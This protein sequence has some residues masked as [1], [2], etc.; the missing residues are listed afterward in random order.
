MSMSL[1]GVKDALP[2]G[3]VTSN[4][5]PVLCR[6]ELLSAACMEYT[7]LLMHAGIRHHNCRATQAAFL[8][9]ASGL[10][11]VLTWTPP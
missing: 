11:A 1:L 5:T 8:Q 3:G 2:L 7:E 6:P 9:S 4:E 10:L